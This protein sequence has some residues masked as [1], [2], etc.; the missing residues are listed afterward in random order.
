MKTDSVQMNNLLGG[1][2]F[3]S[4][5]NSSSGEAERISSRLD[6][7]LLSLKTCQ[8][9]ICRRLWYNLFPEGEVQSLDEALEPHWDGYFDAL[10]R[11]H[12]D[13]C[14]DGYFPA[15]ELPVWRNELVY[16]NK[17]IIS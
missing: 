4:Q 1:S 17:T 7:L 14:R 16:V 2:P 8:G 12:F 15:E 9:S 13:N 6:S 11:V 3:Y 10:P 5:L